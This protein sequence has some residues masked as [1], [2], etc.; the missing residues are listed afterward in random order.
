MSSRQAREVV[1]RGNSSTE[2]LSS[3]VQVDDI[4]HWSVD[5]HVYIL[6]LGIGCGLL[7]SAN[8]ENLVKKKN[9]NNFLWSMAISGEK[10]GWENFP[11][12][13]QVLVWGSRKLP[14]VHNCQYLRSSPWFITVRSALLSA[15]QEAMEAF[16]SAQLISCQYLSVGITKET[17]NLEQEGSHNPW[18][19]SSFRQ[20]HLL[21]L[22]FLSVVGVSGFSGVSQPP[23]TLHRGLWACGL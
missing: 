22:S 2:G 14:Q 16:P 5:T 18:A 3:Q 13:V 4:S 12:M 21:S 1:N 23:S 9:K 15:R 6:W 10:V 8:V 17:R 7:P 19:K 11:G 20:Y